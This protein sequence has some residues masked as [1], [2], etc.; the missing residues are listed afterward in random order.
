MESPQRY[1]ALAEAELAN[2]D[3]N[4]KDLLVAG[5]FADLAQVWATLAVAASSE[6]ARKDADFRH[7]QRSR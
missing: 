5:H 3:A 2:A 6:E 1:A 7:E 4:H